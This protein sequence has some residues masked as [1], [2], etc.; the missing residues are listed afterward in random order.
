M[1]KAFTLSVLFVLAGVAGAYAQIPRII[2]SST[3]NYD[4][5]VS[6]LFQ[7]VDSA[8]YQYTGALGGSANSDNID[9]STSYDYVT[10]AT[11]DTLTNNT[12]TEQTFDS[13]NNL[14]SI[15]GLV[16]DSI[17]GKYVFSYQYLAAYDASNNDTAALYS[18][19]DAAISGW[20]P[21][22]RETASYFGNILTESILQDYDTTTSQFVNN[23]KDSNTINIYGEVAS[24]IYSSWDTAHNDWFYAYSNNWFYNSAGLDTGFVELVYD[25]ADSVWNIN[26]SGSTVFNSDSTLAYS[27]FLDGNAGDTSEYDGYGYDGN[28]NQLFSETLYYNYTTS[29]WDSSDKYTYV[30]NSYNE[31][32]FYEHFKYNASDSLFSPADESFYY[33]GVYTSLPVMT[34]EGNIQLY[35]NPSNNIVHVNA[36]LPAEAPVMLTLYNILGEPVWNL[37]MGNA[38]GIQAMVPV[39]NLSGGLYTLS[40]EQ[41]GATQNRKVMVQR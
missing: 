28:K 33:Y 25:T 11:G 22:A 21:L 15:T 14:T 18:A 2:A 41:N 1:T 40:I 10:A 6:S 27:I 8:T 38:K 32:T 31:E 5:A 36:T 17:E 16:W 9:F 34:D 13:H 12:L 7:L 37:N 30:Y 29:A 3:Y 23:Q 39:N 35:P 20:A 26:F 19:W 24:R 4:T